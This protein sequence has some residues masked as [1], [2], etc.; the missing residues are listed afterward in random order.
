MIRKLLL[1]FG[2]LLVVI[3][4]VAQTTPSEYGDSPD[5]KNVLAFGGDGKETV[6]EMQKDASGNLYVLGNFY[7]KTII[8]SKTIESQGENSNIYLAKFNID[9]KL[10]WITQSDSEISGNLD[11]FQIKLKGTHIYVL[12]SFKNGD[13]LSN[14]VLSGSKPNNYFFAKYD[15]D[16]TLVQKKVLESITTVTDGYQKPIFTFNDTEK[17]FYIAVYNEL[18]SVNE[19]LTQVELKKTYD[20]D[21]L[22]TDILFLN[23]SIFITGNTKR[24][25]ML[26]NV[27]LSFTGRYSSLF[28]A[29]LNT[30]LET[31]W[32]Y[33]AKYDTSDRG[34]SKIGKFSVKNNQLFWSGV[35]NGKETINNLTFSQSGTTNLLPFIVSV[36]ATNGN[37]SSLRWFLQNKVITSDRSINNIKHLINENDEITFLYKTIDFTS[38]NRLILNSGEG[39]EEVKTNVL[40]ENVLSIYGLNGE[41]IKS[42]INTN[43]NLNITKYINSDEQWKQVFVGEN[44]SSSNVLD[45]VSDKGNYYYALV[46]DGRKTNNTFGSGDLALIKVDFNNQIIWS[47]PII[48][49]FNG[50]TSVGN[51]ITYNNGNVFLSGDILGD[52]RIGDQEINP[53]NN[54]YR[55]LLLTKVSSEGVLINHTLINPSTNE[56]QFIDVISHDNGK[57]VVTQLIGN[58]KAKATLFNA[59]LTINK[60]VTFEASTVYILEGTKGK[61]N[62]T[63]LV[64]EFYGDTVTYDGTV[65]N[66]PNTDTAKNGNNVFFELD[67]EF[68]FLNVFNYAHSSK[69]YGS[70]PTSIVSD[71]K[72]NKYIGGVVVYTQ[73][74]SFNNITPNFDSRAPRYNLYYAKVNKDNNFDWVK[75]IGSNELLLNYSS[76]DIDQKGNLYASGYFK[77]KMFIND[78]IE[79][80][81]DYEEGRSSYIIK[82]NTLG[83]VQWVKTIPSTSITNTA[84]V[85]VN[86]TGELVLGGY[87]SKNGT[88]SKGFHYTSKGG[89][90]GFLAILEANKSLTVNEVGLEKNMTVYPNPSN[91]IFNVNTSL[92]TLSKN[93]IYTQVFDLQGRIVYSKMNS[94]INNEIGFSL[95]GYSKGVYIVKITDG[96]HKYSNKIILE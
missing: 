63:Y 86:N 53:V 13:K 76:I 24:D 8:D 91:G 20:V 48:G 71:G 18:H 59:D 90:K 50:A 81:F 56:N 80:S 55:T 4:T 29:S 78:K 79:L 42:N 49:D 51:F 3:S 27:Q 58:K 74:Y 68:N 40:T 14:Q 34:D 6:I 66:K 16:G 23:N 52:V 84:G 21:L 15:I 54:E 45:V 44:G 92:L 43:L 95:K 83:E 2:L 46:E 5:W 94:V 19:E 73:E 35:V 89:S 93:K 36:N 31:N 11:A 33:V 61:D 60:A 9:G 10:L 82:Y 85:A 75:T 1:F 39:A 77:K 62:R 67:S 37:L 32:A 72:G 69:N 26:G 38:L 64:G 30:D 57:I 7:G 41:E 88:F 70:W 28:Y 17:V 96:I 22:I 87:F 25:V 65:Y 47:K 12:G